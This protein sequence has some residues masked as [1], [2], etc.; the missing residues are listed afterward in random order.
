M[1]RKTSTLHRST[2]LK[3]NGVRRTTVDERQCPDLDLARAI[4][5]LLVPEPVLMYLGP[6]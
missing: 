5:N 6:R 4:D 1:Y 3:L 2:G